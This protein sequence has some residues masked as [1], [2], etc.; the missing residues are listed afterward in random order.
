MKRT[1]LFIT[2]L[3]LITLGLGYLRLRPPTATPTALPTASPQPTPTINTPFRAYF[4]IFT[5]GTRRIF[6]DGMYHNLAD[7]AFL[8]AENRDMVT[9]TQPT[10]WGDFFATL[11]FSLSQDCLTTGTGQVF[12][13]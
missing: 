5:N 6:S 4:L 10:T 7:S 1:K 13:T 11:P 12:C 3:V 9:V 2:T 8:T